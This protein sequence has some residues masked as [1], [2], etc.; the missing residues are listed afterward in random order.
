MITLEYQG[1]RDGLAKLEER[2]LAQGLEIQA[3]DIRATHRELRGVIDPDIEVL[4]DVVFQLGTSHKLAAAQE[5][6]R[7]LALT[8][9]VVDQFKRTY[10]K[11]TRCV[12]NE[13]PA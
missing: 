1:P 3:R 9:K 7:E 4:V 5:Q 10:A 12:V 2:L 13:L 11:P 6:G 8:T